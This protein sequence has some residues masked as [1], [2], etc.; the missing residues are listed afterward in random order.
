[1]GLLDGLN[2]PV[3]MASLEERR[4]IVERIAEHYGCGYEAAR[5]WLNAQDAHAM[6][7]AQ[8][9]LAAEPYTDIHVDHWYH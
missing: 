9:L 5:E 7:T 8:R 2:D 1:M 3:L 4:R 6:H